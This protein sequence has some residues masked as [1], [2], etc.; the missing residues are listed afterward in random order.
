[1]LEI[2]SS[3]QERGLGVGF[4]RKRRITGYITYDLST[5]NKSKLAELTDRTH[6]A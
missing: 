6:H 3:K 4:E 1:M 5:W 2:K